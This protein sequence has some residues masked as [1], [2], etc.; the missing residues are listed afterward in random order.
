MTVVPS[1]EVELRG[2]ENPEVG[3]FQVADAHRAAGCSGDP[4]GHQQV[5]EIIGFGAA[6]GGRR[7]ASAV[8]TI[9]SSPATAST[10]SIR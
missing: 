1:S 10:P 5:P 4:H 7:E 8:S 3:Q 2:A 9:T 6:D